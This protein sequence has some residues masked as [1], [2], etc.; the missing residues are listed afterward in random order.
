MINK[1]DY[2][3]EFDSNGKVVISK[4][5]FDKL[6]DD[7]DMLNCLLNCGVNNWDGYDLAEEQFQMLNEGVDN[8]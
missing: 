1:I 4:E 3:W 6:Y 5:Y 2:S 8:D 7:S